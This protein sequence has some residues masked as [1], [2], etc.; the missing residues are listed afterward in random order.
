MLVSN[1]VHLP[2]KIV[3]VAIAPILL[4]EICLAAIVLGGVG[5]LLASEPPPVSSASLKFTPDRSPLNLEAL[6][7]GKTPTG[8]VTSQ[9]MSPTHS[10]IPSLWWIAEQVASEAQFSN[11]LT[12]NWLAYPNGDRGAGRLDLVVNRQLWSLLDY[13]QRYEYINRFGAVARAYG[14][15]IRVFDS[16]AKLVSAY[17]CDFNGV[18][19]GQLQSDSATSNASSTATANTTRPQTADQLTCKLLID[20]SIR[21]NRRGIFTQPK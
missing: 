21:A 16:Q 4:A 17:T 9:T 12:Q 13:L 18:D 2:V 20:T 19:V 7:S 10:T 6:K 15:N 5:Q 3:Q 1:S 11:K 8:V 14:Y